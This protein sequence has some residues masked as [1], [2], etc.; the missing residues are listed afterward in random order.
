MNSIQ[1]LR[2]LCATAV[3]G[4]GDSSV[5]HTDKSLAFTTWAPT[6]TLSLFPP[7]KVSKLSPRK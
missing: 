6:S 2:P 3:L 5:T 7:I 4:V 1:F